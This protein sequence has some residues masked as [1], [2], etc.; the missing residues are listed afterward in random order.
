MRSLLKHHLT[1][2]YLLLLLVVSAA[3][4][5]TGYGQPNALFWDEN[6][7]IA[8]AEKYI[9]GVMYMEPHPPLGKLLMAAS[10]QLLGA[11]ADKDKS[12]FTHTD[13][14][15]D[16]DMPDGGIS[17]YGF[18]L[19]STVLMALS[20]LFMFGIIRR[21][22]KNPH[23]ALAFCCFLIFDNALV[24]HARSAMLE[25]IQLFF[26]LA[27][28]YYTVRIVTTKPRITLTQYALLGTLIGLAV[29]VKINALVLLLLFVLVYGVDQWQAIKTFN[30]AALL[31]R[32]ATTVPSGVV[33]LGVSFLAVF[34]IHIGLGQTISPHKNYSAS[35]EYQQL[36]KD[37][38]SW[39]PST[40]FVALQ[41]N[42]KY[43][44]N[45]ADGVPRLD[46]CKAGEN[47]SAAIGWPLASKTINY[48]WSKRTVDD[49]TYVR[50][51]NLVANP[52]VWFGVLAGIILS[53]GLIIS[54][55]IY[56]NPVK[57]TAL[58][59]WICGF[60][61]LY[62][63]YMVAILQIERVMYMYHYL[64]PLVFGII[65]LALV[66]SYIFR[67]QLL[68]SSRHTYINL[69]V[70]VAFTIGVFYVFAPFTY[71]WELTEAQF[72]I[73]DWF[74]YWKLQVVR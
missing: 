68:A 63:S 19:P 45:Y 55:F 11:N 54:R 37:G 8:S 48:R 21:T 7:H 22:S 35:S 29:A 18:R 64:V 74:D 20:V 59:Y 10:E 34:Y 12:K 4:Y 6:Y 65:N 36:I 72:E 50:Y 69:G 27:A 61:S 28:I 51:H 14:V 33:P 15:R 44:S 52:V 26:I 23:I 25:G 57:D 47:G 16:N 9:D 42:L 43:M 41:D 53:I 13:Y 2:I 31:K 5:V 56:N 40:F 30:I 70:L 60:T 17:Y 66:F 67:E 32:L 49:T 62:V 38:R 24:I 1:H 39:A 71:S 46:V 3:V 73:R 58:F